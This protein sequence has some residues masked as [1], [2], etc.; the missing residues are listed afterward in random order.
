MLNIN[1]KDSNV[2]QEMQEKHWNVPKKIKK[3]I[4]L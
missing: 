3:I 2:K 1:V 4:V